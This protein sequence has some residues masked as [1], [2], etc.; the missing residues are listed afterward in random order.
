MAL[1][2]AATETRGIRTPRTGEA[3]QS[4]WLCRYEISAQQSISPIEKDDPTRSFGSASTDAVNERACES[5]RASREQSNVQRAA[6]R[7]RAFDVS[8]SMEGSRGPVGSRARAHGP[9]LRVC[10]SELAVCD[11]TSTRHWT[12][13]TMF[14][15][16]VPSQLDVVQTKYYGADQTRPGMPS[17]RQPT[18][19]VRNKRGLCL[20]CNVSMF[21]GRVWRG[22]VTIV[23]HCQSTVSISCTLICISLHL[24]TLLYFS[25]GYIYS[26][27]E[28]S[29]SVPV[30]V[31][32]VDPSTSSS[33][34]L[35]I[36]FSSSALHYRTSLDET[37]L[38]HSTPVTSHGS[39]HPHDV[40]DPRSH[41]AN[42][43]LSATNNQRPAPSATHPS[44][45]IHTQTR[46]SARHHAV[47]ART[48]TRVWMAHRCRPGRSG[49]VG[50]GVQREAEAKTGEHHVAL[51][52]EF[53]F[54]VG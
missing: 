17:S 9:S 20:F 48:R 19:S 1:L 50:E 49:R 27:C 16:H 32:V 47:P 6:V 24:T 29:G 10:S 25:P 34:F 53:G 30:S 33:V 31:C 18:R 13:T 46:Q 45:Q 21:G 4:R 54:A 39:H 8:A 35:L 52:L 11:V 51:E 5:E 23:V 7:G 15:D 38:L 22:R 12:L 37:F 26:S 41:P 42:L 2:G 40:R 3:M 44:P 14:I 28:A 43:S 36:I